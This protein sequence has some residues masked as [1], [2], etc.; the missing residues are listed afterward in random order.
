MEE[1]KL[2]PWQRCAGPKSGQM[3]AFRS[4]V[5]S[6]KEGEQK[7]ETPFNH[8]EKEQF[9]EKGNKFFSTTSFNFFLSFEQH[10][11]AIMSLLRLAHNGP[12]FLFVLSF[13]YFF[14][15]ISSS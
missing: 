11:I 12:F 4:C 7:K 2:P 15:E 6:K 5:N 8:V 14:F 10:L 13:S 9:F 1:S 3:R